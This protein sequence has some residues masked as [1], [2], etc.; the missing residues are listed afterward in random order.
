MHFVEYNAISIRRKFF[1][2]LI[3]I[4]ALLLLWNLINK[5]FSNIQAV[6][7][8]DAR[9][10]KVTKEGN[11]QKPHTREIDPAPSRVK[12]KNMEKID[13]VAKYPND[14]LPRNDYVKSRDKGI[15]TGNENASDDKLRKAL[16]LSIESTF[17]RHLTKSPL[18]ENNLS[19]PFG[20]TGNAKPTTTMPSSDSK[21]ILS[22][23]SPHSSKQIADITEQ[24]VRKSI[25]GEL[26]CPDNPWREDLSEL[27]RAWS[28]I[29][30]QNQIEYVLA[31]G[32]LLG[33][34]RD[35]DVIPY[36]SD[37]DILVDINYFSTMKRLSV[38]R[39]FNSEDG[40]I[41]LV[42]QPEFSLNIR[43][44]ERKRFDCNGK[45]ITFRLNLSVAAFIYCYCCC[46][47]QACDSGF[48]KK[49]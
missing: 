30:K 16:E 24:P 12:K 6:F 34:M 5:D 22:T 43:V 42:V 8:N 14:Y 37:I 47:F 20:N 46:R 41:R 3:F 21:P 36:D 25:Y 45:V 15:R 11:W 48:F 17:N 38:R 28:N 33:A 10:R 40:K 49:S 13:T 4:T 27:F 23:T 18:L 35:G 39:N 9:V 1:V 26:G 44:D 31:C 7:A 32:S 19:F 2:F 29:S